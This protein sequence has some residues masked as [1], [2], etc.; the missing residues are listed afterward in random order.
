MMTSIQPSESIGNSQDITWA[1]SVACSF[2][3]GWRENDRDYGL[4]D[5][6]N[7]TYSSL[8][9]APVHPDASVSSCSRQSK[10]LVIIAVRQT[11]RE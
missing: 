3:P 9:P 1:D 2:A 7:L 10:F 11:R 5:V 8:S 4:A 6:V